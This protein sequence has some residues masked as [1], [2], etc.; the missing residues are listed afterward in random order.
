MTATFHSFGYNYGNHLRGTGL[1]THVLA[2]TGVSSHLH[3]FPNIYWQPRIIFEN[4]EPFGVVL[5]HSILYIMDIKKFHVHI[6]N[7]VMDALGLE[8]E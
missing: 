8:T 5:L 3:H 2:A 1:E 4:T 6:T 7:L